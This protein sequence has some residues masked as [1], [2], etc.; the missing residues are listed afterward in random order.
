[1]GFPD[2]GLELTF[3]LAPARIRDECGLCLSPQ[4]AKSVANA[5]VWAGAQC[6]DWGAGGR[7]RRQPVCVERIVDAEVAGVPCMRQQC[8]TS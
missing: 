8:R 1:M 7:R 3:L 2:G 5:S 6:F 4:S